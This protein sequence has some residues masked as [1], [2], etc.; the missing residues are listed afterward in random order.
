MKQYNLKLH[1]A[2]TRLNELLKR[3]NSQFELVIMGSFALE[4]HHIYLSRST[5]DIDTLIRID[6]ELTEEI[7][8]VA[9][10]LDL[11]SNWISDDCSSISPLPKGFEERLILI[12][13]HSH[14][15]IQVL[16]LKDI[17]ATKISALYSRGHTD[18]KDLEDLI[19]IHPNED[20]IDFGI[21]YLI[22]AQRP[23]ANVKFQKE[24]LVEVE[25]LR[26]ELKLRFV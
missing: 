17:I 16:S 23:D 20:D 3:R 26:R 9:D 12:T 24:F 18:L 22:L 2:L 7:E 14:I 6:D 1:H 25:N 8:I 19:Q 5:N 4:L 11:N 21:D 13:S 15:K 10:E